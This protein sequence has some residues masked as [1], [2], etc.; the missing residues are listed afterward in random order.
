ML[1]DTIL[2]ILATEGPASFVTMGLEGPHMAATWNS[3][4]SVH[5]IDEVLIPVGS[6]HQ[7]EENVHHGSEVQMIIASKTVTGIHGDG[8]GFLLTGTAV[9][10]K[11]GTHFEQVKSSF[12]WARAVMVLHITDIKQLI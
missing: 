8:A 6:L 9:F 10:E 3:Y 7:T 4:I 5:G 2:E 12:S 1:N 11:V